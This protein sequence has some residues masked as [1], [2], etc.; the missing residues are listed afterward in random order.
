MISAFIVDILKGKYK[1]MSDTEFTQYSELEKLTDDDL[2]TM[3]IHGGDNLHIH[4][5]KVSVAKRILENRR[6]LKQL[7]AAKNVEIMT[8]QLETSHKEL[9][10]IVNGLGQIVGLLEFV[11]KHWLPR[12]SMW[13]RI[14][15]FVTGTVLLGIGLNLAADWIAKF[16]FKW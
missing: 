7:E 10:A 12:Q 6:Q 15:T 4:M 14:A 2:E 8:R 3:V 5:S 11:K 1:T 9:L 16:I 13:V